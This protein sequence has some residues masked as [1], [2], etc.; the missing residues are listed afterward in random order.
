MLEK[1]DSFDH[2]QMKIETFEFSGC[3]HENITPKD[4]NKKC[5]INT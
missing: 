5:N 2:D 4:Y 1:D 3:I